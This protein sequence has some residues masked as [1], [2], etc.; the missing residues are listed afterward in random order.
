[1]KQLFS[2]YRRLIAYTVATVAFLCAVAF[3]DI[4]LGHSLLGII[5]IGACAELE[6]FAT[7]TEDLEQRI[8]RSP[9]LD[10][11]KFWWNAVPH[12]TFVKNKGVTSTTFSMKPS[13]PTD[14]PDA[15]T[16]ITLDDVSGQPT[17]S[18]S[19]DFE[20][21]DVGFYRRT[22]SPKRRDFR[23]PVLCK[24]DFTFQ[25]DIDAFLDG[26]VD[27]IGK[28]L[29]R[30][31]EFALR[32]DYMSFG[33][34]F[35]DYTKYAG[36]HPDLTGIPVPTSDLTQDML[37][38]VASDLMDVGA[39]L[40]DGMG[41]TM[42]SDTGPIWALYIDKRESAK[43]L[44]NNSDLRE[45]ARFASMGS[46]AEGDLAL[47]KAIGSTRVIGNFRHRLTDIAPRANNVNGV[48]VPVTP[49]KAVG[50][51]GSDGETLTAA[52]KA[53]RYEAA[54]VV[55]TGVMQADI[56]TPSNWRFPNTANYM[57]DLQ[58]II[59]GNTICDP[60][61]YDPQGERG[62]HFANIEYAPKPA[63]PYFAKTIW[64]KKCPTNVARSTCASY[65]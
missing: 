52:Y 30:I 11:A 46:G 12:G 6:E 17:P 3:T 58:F 44:K 9:R 14:N 43:I 50:A 24:R 15:W 27:E 37:D 18:C 45:D 61:V 28:Y 63:R 13:E 62:R 22:Y 16:T 10:R 32:S 34:I 47:I 26:Y 48:L 35:V 36:P 33:D 21:I 19:A 31:W 60:P 23:G 20:D 40:P 38:D 53:A 56:V 1:M 29:T 65:T 41:Y 5:A 25:H 42:E 4:S 8:L 55:L 7:A 39:G 51:I 64:F 2:T 49:F 54:V 57:G 59:G